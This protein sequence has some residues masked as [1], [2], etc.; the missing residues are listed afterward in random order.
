MAWNNAVVTNAGISLLKQVLAGAKL[1]VSSAMGGTGTVSPASLMAQTALTNP[2]QSIAIVAATETPAGRKLRLE[3]HNQGLATA[4][5]LNQI[6]IWAKIDPG[7]PVLFAIL[8]DDP[9]IQVPAQSTNPEFVLYFYALL[10]FGNEGEV[11]VVLD[12]EA[13]VSLKTLGEHDADPDAHS[14]LQSAITAVSDDLSI[15]EA[16]KGNPHGVTKAQV[17]LG[18]V[19]NTA[20]AAKPISTATQAALDGKEPTIA[21]GAETQYLKGNKTWADFATDVRGALLTGLQTVASA[22]IAAGDSMIGA[23]QKLQ[24]QVTAAIS[25]AATAQ[26]TANSAQTTANS[27]EPTITAGTTSQYWRGDKSWQTLPTVPTT[28]GAVGAEP[29]IAAGTTAQYWRG[30]KSWQAMNAAAVGL[31]NVTNESKAT[32]LANAALTGAPTAPTP[33][34][35]GGVAIKSYVDSAVASALPSGGTVNQY[36]AGNK[37]LVDFDLSVLSSQIS[38][39]IPDYSWIESSL[40][41]STSSWKSICY[42][43]GL[44]VVVGSPLTGIYLLTSPNGVDWILRN[45]GTSGSSFTS[46]CYGNGLF[47]AVGNV[48]TDRIMTSQNGTTWTV[49]KNT[50]TYSWMEVCY[51]NGLFVATVYDSSGNFKIMTSPDGINW[52]ERAI[53]VNNSFGALCYGNDIFVAVASSGTGNRV[54][55]SP[56]GINWTIRQSSADNSWSSVCYGNGLFVAVASSGTGN[57]VMTSPDGINW[58][59]RVSVSNCSWTS[60]CYGDG[61]F[62]AVGS[63]GTGRVMTSPDGVNWTARANAVDKGWNSVCY[64]DGLFV[65]TGGTSAANG[66]MVSSRYANQAIMSLSEVIELLLLSA[67]IL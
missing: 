20:D 58:T 42:G 36:F 9:G 47:V 1:D 37:T 21:A 41:S 32:I 28:P 33:T 55:T 29:A 16:D 60:V 45:A 10:Q 35:A 40:P 65:A 38:R 53:P 18:S 2:K 8:Q 50:N 26:T 39:W 23:L 63:N 11:E 17:G 64:G 22:T 15:H 13:L 56:D 34:V 66:V 61:L 12:P 49:Q 54:M 59:T 43:N 6:G 46:V 3:I 62:V 30:D 24:A 48:G 57:R 51:G 67:K 5:T 44:F 14:P 4:Y 25:A 27:K 31:G 19:D 7:A 52:T